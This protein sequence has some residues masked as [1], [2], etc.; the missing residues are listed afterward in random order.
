MI[1][2]VP[3]MLVD[4]QIRPVARLVDRAAVRKRLRAVMR[5]LIG[6]LP[7]HEQGEL[8]RL[9]TKLGEGLAVPALEPAPVRVRSR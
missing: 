7:P 1:G 4:R 8:L 2:A 3:G 6:G 5:E 9:L